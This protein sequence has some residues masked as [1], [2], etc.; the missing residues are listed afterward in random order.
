MLAA[1]SHGSEQQVAPR[2]GSV[3]WNYNAL[4]DNYHHEVAPRMGSVGCVV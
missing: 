3:G 1:W 4:H 2:M